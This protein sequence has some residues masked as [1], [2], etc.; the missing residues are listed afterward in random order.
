MNPIFTG[1][2]EYML[3]A[4]PG[5]RFSG[6]IAPA[7]HELVDSNTVHIIDLLFIK[8]DAEGNVLVVELDTLDDEEGAM[9]DEFDGDLEDLL[10][11]DDIELMAAELPNNSAAD[12]LVWENLWAARFAQA[13]RNAHGE[14]I[15][16][17]RIP[18]ELIQAAHAAIM[19]E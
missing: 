5:N 16:N 13:I 2:V 10:S 4:F 3:I 14:V 11:M 9:F 1:P 18:H 8:K 19:A 17:E 7:L 15:A 12:L 6:E